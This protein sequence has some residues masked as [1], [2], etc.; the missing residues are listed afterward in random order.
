MK[1]IVDDPEGFFDQGGWS[2]LDP[3][4][5]AENGEDDDDDDEED[6]QYTP[7]ESE[8]SDED[9]SESE[10]EEDESEMDYSGKNIFDTGTGLIHSQL[11]M[12]HW[13]LVRSLGKIGP[14]WR[15]R[16][17]KLTV[18]TSSTMKT[19]HGRKG[20]RCPLPKP[21]NHRNRSTLHPPNTDHPS[22][23]AL[24]PSRGKMTVTTNRLHHTRSSR[25]DHFTL[26]HSYHCNETRIVTEKNV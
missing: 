9:D 19:R 15:K 23:M 5:D 25:N 14:S 18:I 11:Q 21:G 6:D 16:L 24:L 7:T 20:I 3:D 22:R 4:S 8:D 2:F 1:T 17:E 12:N 10:F 13:P 26:F